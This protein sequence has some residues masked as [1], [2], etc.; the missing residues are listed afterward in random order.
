MATLTQLEY[1]VAVDQCRHFGRAAALCFVSQPT[2][3][4]QLQKLE[5]ELGYALFDRNKQPILATEDGLPFIEQAKVVVNEYRRFLALKTKNNDQQTG[6][7]RVG[8]IPT[9][10]P[11][12]MPFVLEAFTAKHP[13]IQVAVE[14]LSTQKIVEAL[15]KDQIDVGV[16]ATPL[17]ISRIQEDTLYYEPFFAYVAPGHKLERSIRVSE[18]QLET[19]ELWLPADEHCLRDQMID[20]CGNSQ[21]EGC[22]PSVKLRGGSLETIIELVSQGRGYTLLPQLAADAVKRRKF[23]GSIHEMVRP[24]PAREISLVYRRGYFKQRLLNLFKE[25]VLASAPKTLPRERSK[26][27]RVLGLE[28]RFD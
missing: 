4:V 26:A 9:V 3:S 28:G 2:L 7:L 27:F 20:V 11:Y 8:V 18:Q 12:L 5:D 22:F 15:D 1:V 16:A 6:E 17:G 23:E 13:K 21:G 19:G 14:E 25:I 24:A 10:S